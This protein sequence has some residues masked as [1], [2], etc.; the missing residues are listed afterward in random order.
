MHD[1]ST[2][3]KKY[4]LNPAPGSVGIN[5]KNKL[6]QQYQYHRYLSMP[7]TH[8]WPNL[9]S[10]SH[11]LFCLAFN[12][13]LIFRLQVYSSYFY[14]FSYEPPLTSFFYLLRTIC[15]ISCCEILC[16]LTFSKLM[17]NGY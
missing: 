9:V 14:R 7:L 1:V 16:L 4:P 15:H 11:K 2:L 5:I 12:T 10:D 6:S 13:S 8:T 3:L 17:P